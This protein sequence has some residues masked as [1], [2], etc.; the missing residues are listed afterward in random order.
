[1][2]MLRVPKEEKRVVW[3]ISAIIGITL[4][5]TALTNMFYLKAPLIFRPDE[6]LILAF[7]I[8][9]FPPA[10]TNFLDSRWK[11]S[12]D[13]NIPK[14]LKEISEAGRTGVTLIRAIE[15]SAERSY[16]PLSSELKRVITQLSWGVSLEDALKSF[17]ERVDTYL[18][19]WVSI[20]ISEI[21]KAGGD[22]R[23]VLEMVSEH[24]R[25]LQ[26]IEN[27]RKVQLRPYILVVY[28]AFF[29][30]LFI[31]VLLIKTLFSQMISLQE[32]LQAIGGLFGG[33][34]IN[35]SQI[36]LLMFHMG[37]IGG[38][39]SGL[40]A[41]K[42]GEGTIGAGLK[43]SLILVVIVLLAFFFFVWHPII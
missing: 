18:A 16:G 9:I 30:F 2:L 29:I 37:I 15:L 40:V 6:L 14:M 33:A 8:S 12:I 28:L 22:I 10:I 3:I 4:T 21:N 27:E 42:M 1:M 32:Q 31:D 36:E 24:I 41:G 17:A 38:F 7:I 23:E 5:I 34:V 13:N 19:R 20:L 26:T 39:Y 43:H 11:S 35:I 25:E